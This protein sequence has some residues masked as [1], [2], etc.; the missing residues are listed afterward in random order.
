MMKRSGI[1]ALG[2]ILIGVG[3]AMGQ[4]RLFPRHAP[5]NPPAPLPQQNPF[6]NLGNALP[7]PQ[8]NLGFQSPT[9]GPGVFVGGTS[10]NTPGFTFSAFPGYFGYNPWMSWYNPWTNPWMNPMLNPLNAWNNF[11]MGMQ[12]WGMWNQFGGMNLNTMNP[13]NNAV[14]PFGNPGNLFNWGMP[15]LQNNGFGMGDAPIVGVGGQ[16]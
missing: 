9:G 3:S 11:N 1:L 12:P 2:V 16:P 7:N 13:F 6:N 14:V 8:P 5:G 10:F 15:G 4:F